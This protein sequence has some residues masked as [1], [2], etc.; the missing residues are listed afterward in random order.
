MF[1]HDSTTTEA[2]M[3]PSIKI[4]LERRHLIFLEE[5]FLNA[6]SAQ[7]LSRSTPMIENTQNPL[8]TKHL[9]TLSKEEH[10]TLLDDLLSLFIEIGLDKESEPT[11]TGLFIEEIIDLV[12]LEKKFPEHR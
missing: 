12:H 8:S 3:T 10:Q 1:V 4:I 11:A 7:L 6:Y 2:I 5:H 9:L